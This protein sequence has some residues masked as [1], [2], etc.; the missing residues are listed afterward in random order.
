MLRSVVKYARFFREVVLVYPEQDTKQIAETILETAPYLTT[1]LY[2]M[3][4]PDRGHLRQCAHKT[5]ADLFSNADFFLHL[6]S[7]T[8]LTSKATPLDYSTGGKADLY[9]ANYDEL[10]FAHDGRPP[11]WQGITQ[12]ALNIPVM[13]ETMRQFP[14]LYPRWLYKLTR[15]RIES[16]HTMKFMDYVLTAPKIGAAFHGYCEFNSLG[17]MAFYQFP[18]HF[19]LIHHGVELSKPTHVKQFWS[20]WVREN[21]AKFE[22]EIRPELELIT[23]DFHVKEPAA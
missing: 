18:E 22:S 13:V 20:H 11:P 2:P 6:D 10:G 12:H 8:L 3:P 14:F 9:W 23:K 21:I 4:E 16:V 17:C 5:S 7:D 15:D 19:N 1:H